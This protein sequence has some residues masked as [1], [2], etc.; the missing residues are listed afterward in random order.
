MCEDRTSTNTGMLLQPDSQP[1]DTARLVIAINKVLDPGRALN[2]ACHLVAGI[3][4][5][6]G[7]DGQNRLKFL[8]FRDADGGLHQ[9]ISAR[10]FIVLRATQGELRKLR[11]QA[12]EANVPYVD[13]TQTMTGGTYIDQLERTS[14]TSDEELEYFGVALFGL[15]ADTEG[16]TRRLSL[17]R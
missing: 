10:S 5:L 16:F 17:W 14:R 11:L 2:V 6:V 13:F 8:E 7:E 4:N 15:K 12:R 3:T 1:D 9:S